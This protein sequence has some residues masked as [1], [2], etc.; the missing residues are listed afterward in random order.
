VAYLDASLVLVHRVD[1]VDLPMLA[2]HP[3]CLSEPV[4]KV[5]T[6]GALAYAAP[7]F[8]VAYFDAITS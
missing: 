5:L 7:L 6:Q 1:M 3:V 8:S 4:F 2:F